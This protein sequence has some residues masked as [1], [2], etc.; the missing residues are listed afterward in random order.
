MDG[1]L[2]A[3]LS[4]PI[5]VPD[6]AFRLP[7]HL[8]DAGAPRVA[9]YK[10]WDEPMTE[11]WQRW[12]F[13]QHEMPYDTLHDADI[14][15]GALADYD[16]LVFQAQS[17]ESI[18]GGFEP[19]RVPPPYAG[20]LGDAGA[21]AVADFVRGGGRVVAVEAATDFVRD[22]FDLGVRDVTRDLPNT[23]FYIPGS[24]LRLELEPGSE[25]TGGMQDEVAAWYWR[26][27]MAFEV[28]DDRVRVA[29]RY[30]T[31][32][33]LLS[34][35]VLGGQHVAGRPAILEADVGEGS[36]VLFGFQ[37]NYRAQTMATWPLLFNALRK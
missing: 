12:V 4:Q 33:P 8:S 30:G 36:V 27:S 34:G 15:G 6:F 37:P 11:G 10:S 19:G 3:R 22:L 35:W 26:S 13:D 18:L 14:R 32:D 16:V 24:I 20:G 1:T 9:L 29:A 25:L 31:G 17:A 23:E 28:S 21:A 7:E 2:T 5:S